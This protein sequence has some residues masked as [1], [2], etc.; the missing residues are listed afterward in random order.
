MHSKASSFAVRGELSRYPIYNCLHTR[1]HKFLFHL[2]EISEGN[3]LIQNSPNSLKECNIL[4][5]ARK[6]WLSTISNLLQLKDLD[7]T[8]LFIVVTLNPK[9]I[10]HNVENKLKEL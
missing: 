3:P 9:Q 4:L 1:L 6:T 10:F 8:Q 5:N 2:L 7:L